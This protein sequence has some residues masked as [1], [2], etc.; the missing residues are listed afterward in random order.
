[1][2]KIENWDHLPAAVRQHLIDQMCDRAIS[3]ADL[4]QRRGE[5]QP[6]D[7]LNRQPAPH[8]RSTGRAASLHARHPPASEVTF[9]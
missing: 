4:N 5:R 9:V 1:M 8:H 6:I 7:L 3:I 2:P